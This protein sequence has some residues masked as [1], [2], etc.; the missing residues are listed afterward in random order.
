MTTQHYSDDDIKK[1]IEQG[2]V[3]EWGQLRKSFS[4]ERCQQIVRLCSPELADKENLSYQYWHQISQFFLSNHIAH[5][6]Q[7]T[8]LS[9]KAVATAGFRL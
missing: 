4:V 3:R 5:I 7:H 1:T 8:A 6:R 2:N 9:E